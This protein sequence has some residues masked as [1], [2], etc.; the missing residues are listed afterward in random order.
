MKIAI[1]I[2]PI[3]YGTGVSVYTKNLVENLLS[4]DKE[5]QYLLFGG[6]LRRQNELR[7]YVGSLNNKNIQ[8][9]ILPT[10][11][12]LAD[13]VW[14]R[15]HIFPIENIVGNIDVFH[16]SDWTQPPA[17]AFKVTTIHDLV[18]I[19]HPEYSLPKLVAVHRRRLKW[20]CKEVDKIIVPSNETKKDAVSI[21]IEE[22]KIVVIPEAPDPVFKPSSESEINI[23][24]SKFGIRGKY[25][26]SIGVNPR[27]NTEKIVESIRKIRKDKKYGDFTHVVV[28][29]KYVDQPKRYGIMYTGHV[30]SSDIVKLYS[31]ASALIYPSLYEGFGLPILEAYACKTP[32]VTSDL[33]SMREIGK[34]A[35]VLVNPK[36]MASIVNGIRKVL[37]SPDKYINLGLKRVKK[38]SWKKTAQMTLKVYQDSSS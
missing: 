17:K 25:T 2:S 27:K 1:D 35:A 31:G 9:N 7:D 18:P 5:N 30:E 4:I 11:P 14:N 8:R 15:L 34:G 29:H 10:P 3:I 13:V 21:G 22:N 23:V 6:S 28:G 16:A 20:V 32:V 37:D 19:K 24:K 26:V 38:Y 12:L 36:K 33:G